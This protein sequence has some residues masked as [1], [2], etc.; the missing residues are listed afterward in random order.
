MNKSNTTIIITTWNSLSY[1]KLCLSKIKQYTSIP[2]NIVVVDNGSTDGTKEFLNER[3]SDR[4]LNLRHETN[5]GTNQAL[6]TAEK[7]IGTDYVVLLDS[8][9]VVSPLWLENFISIKAQNDAVKAIGPIK[10]STQLIHPY[11]NIN[12]RVHWDSLKNQFRSLT[13]E[14]QLEKYCGDHHYESFVQDFIEANYFDDYFL[15]CPPELLSGCCLFLDFNF[16]KKIGGITNTIFR[17]YGGHDADR[18]WRIAKAGGKV[19]KA[20][21]IYVHHFEGSSLKKN[22]LNYR[23]LLYENNR[24]LLN[25]WRKQFWAFIELEIKNGHSL[26]SLAK[27]YWTV[28]EIILS[29]DSV[30]IPVKYASEAKEVRFQLTS[31]V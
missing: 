19:L 3:S 16:M 4:F 1:L 17:Q 13:P 22:S 14:R 10:P 2:H 11:S 25:I 29:A 26:L 23:P 24:L 30:Q 21:S 6:H 8:D 7:Y 5:L 9:V 31:T 27:R 20:N 15:T 18:C 28:R 12:S